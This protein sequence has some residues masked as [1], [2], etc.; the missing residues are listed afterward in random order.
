MKITTTNNIMTINETANIW[1]IE[2]YA[3]RQA[4][5]SKC[6]KDDEAHSEKISIY[7]IGYQ[8]RTIDEFIN[9]LIRHNIN[10][11]IDVRA[12][13]LSRKKGFSKKSLIEY[14]EKNE[15]EYIPYASLGTPKKLRDELKQNKDYPVFFDKYD[16]WLTQQENIFRTLQYKIIDNLNKKFCIMCFEKNPSECHRSIIA[17]NLQKKTNE[18]AQVKNI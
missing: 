17:Y 7:T 4:I 16:K 1:S 9:I 11:I 2:P 12:N 10:T 15:I 18:I 3:I 6:F 8:E 14:L 5:N 13:P